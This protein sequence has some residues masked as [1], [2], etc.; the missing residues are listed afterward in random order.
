MKA[1]ASSFGRRLRVAFFMHDLSGGGVE[2]MRLALIAELQASGVEVSLVLAAKRGA[3]L[4]L[5]PVDLKVVTLGTTRT[6][7]TIAKLARFL[8]VE[9]ADVLVSSLDHNNIAAMLARRFSGVGTRLVICQHNALSGAQSAGW[10]YRVVPWVYW[11]L[12]READGVVAVS[13]G[14]ADELSVV[15]GIPRHK[16]SVIYNPV[17]D[18]GF[19]ERAGGPAPH[20]WLARKEY[21]VFVFVG[22]LTAQKDAFT[23]LAALEMALRRREVRLILLGEGEDE[24]ELRLCA[25]EAGIAHAVAFAGFQINPLPWIRH[26]DALISSSR[27]EGLGNAIVEALACGTQVIAT[28]C[29]HGPAEILFE[30][31]LGKL[32]PPGDVDALAKAIIDHDP[33]FCDPAQLRARGASFCATACAKAHL[34]LFAKLGD[35]KEKIVHALGMNIS[36]MGTDEVVEAIVAEGGRGGVQLVVTPNLDHVRNLRSPEFAAAYASS[37]LVCPDGLP[38]LLYARLRGL[39]LRARVTGCDL[40]ARLIRHVELRRHTLFLVV[41]C[42]MTAMAASRWADDL[43]LQDRVEIAVA[44]MALAADEQAQLVLAQKIAA[45]K[46]SILVMTLGAP[47]SEIFVHRNRDR[48]PP[49]WALCVGQA[50]RVEL[51]LARRA[52][53]LWQ[54]L[55]LEWL[56]RLGHEPGRLLRRYAQSL[57]WFP[58]AIWLD[59]LGHEKKHGG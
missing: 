22:R 28:D 23:L 47:A 39:R 56:W 40:F 21:P 30:G 7:A 36:P 50:L 54:S 57:A 31:K 15:A 44:P 1:Q 48:L 42:R 27:Y 9:Q 26:A 41:E 49:C 33:V 4:P 10:K 17:I 8:S 34:D 24:Q 19:F 14:V 3:L 38:V 43:G 18:K 6:I 59:V 35:G 37:A 58:V 12:H 53:K 5:L 51:A 46:P 20:I 52:P 29:P 16:I 32:V 13:S 45:A 55:G 2:R 25:R 11:L